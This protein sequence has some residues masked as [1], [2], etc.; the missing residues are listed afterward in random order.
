[1]FQTTQEPEFGFR[2]LKLVNCLW[3]KVLRNIYNLLVR[4]Q[5]MKWK[6]NKAQGLQ[7]I[8]AVLP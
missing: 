5:E 7:Q 6:D 4:G 1:M 2:I 3:E 8:Q